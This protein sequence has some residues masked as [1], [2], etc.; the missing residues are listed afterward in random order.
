MSNDVLPSFMTW[1][2]TGPFGHTLSRT[3]VTFGNLSGF[4]ACSAS[5]IQSDPDGAKKRKFQEDKP[6]E[7]SQKK[8]KQDESK[9]RNNQLLFSRR[10]C[11]EVYKHL[12][13][14]KDYIPDNFM[15][16]E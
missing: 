9:T 7:K 8:V 4:G 15:V 2:F 12:V 11:E 10:N 3:P 6:S 14:N 16:D 1:T 5:P 13:E